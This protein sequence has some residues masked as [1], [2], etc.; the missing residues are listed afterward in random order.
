MKFYHL[1]IFFGVLVLIAPKVGWT[2]VVGAGLVSVVI[3]L[4]AGLARFAGLR[5]P[6]Q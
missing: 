6:R 4:L 1:F 5:P 2:V 3:L